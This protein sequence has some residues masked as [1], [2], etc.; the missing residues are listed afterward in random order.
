MKVLNIHGYQGSPENSA[1]AA[2]RAIGVDIESPA[3]DYDASSPNEVMELLRK[4][5]GKE[6]FD[7]IV[8]TSF[9]GFFAAVLAAEVQL[10]VILVNPCLLP[11]L[12]LPRLGYKGNIRELIPLFG[13]LEELNPGASSC[14]IGGQDEILDTHDFTKHLLE[15]E[16]FCIIPNGRHSGSTLPLEEYF[17]EIILQTS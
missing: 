16:R 11:F 2:L 8:G 10:P 17:K 1:Y 15:N 13:K 7:Y 9:G 4:T 6:S 5:V 14:I 3:I 12:S